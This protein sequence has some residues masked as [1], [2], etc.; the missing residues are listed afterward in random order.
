MLLLLL[1]L[2]LSLQL[3]GDEDENFEGVDNGRFDEVMNQ[4]L[5]DQCQTICAN[6]IAYCAMIMTNKGVNDVYAVTH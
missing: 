4:Q 5:L 6:L 2:L 1:T 3:E